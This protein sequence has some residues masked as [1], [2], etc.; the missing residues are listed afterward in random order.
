MSMRSMCSAG[1]CTVT[2]QGT[3]CCRQ[4]GLTPVGQVAFV[5]SIAHLQSQKGVYAD[6]YLRDC[7]ASC[8]HT[9]VRLHQDRELPFDTIGNWKWEL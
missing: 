1:T 5:H 7:P 8:G 4:Y 2:E 3:T 9:H 6:A